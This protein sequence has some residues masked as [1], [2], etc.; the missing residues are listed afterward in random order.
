M[1]ESFIFANIESDDINRILKNLEA[2][3]NVFKK[4]TVIVMDDVKTIGILI[5]GHANIE[6]YDYNGNRTI[7]EKLEKNSIFGEMFLKLGSDITITTTS[8]CEILF[9]DYERILKY[10]KNT[11]LINNIFAL[12]ATKILNL[13]ARLEILSK[14]TIRDKIMTY[15]LNLANCKNTKTFTLSFNYADLADYLSVNRSAMMRELKKLEEDG[16]IRKNGKKIDLTNY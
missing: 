1:E 5:E 3:K 12:L 8:D 16:Y 15:F 2:K 13:N 6:K 14:R 10:S 9:V 7:I 11:A 4:N